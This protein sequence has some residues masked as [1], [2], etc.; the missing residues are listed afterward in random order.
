VLLI[1]AHKSFSPIERLGRALCRAPRYNLLKWH[2]DFFLLNG[3]KIRCL[4]TWLRP[5]AE[6]A[7]GASDIAAGLSAI[8]VVSA[9]IC[10]GT[11]LQPVCPAAAG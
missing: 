9:A 7:T 10:V 8:N 11:P 2:E 6:N 3:I 5:N 1:A 4:T